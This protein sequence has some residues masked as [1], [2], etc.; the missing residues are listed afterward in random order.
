MGCPRSPMA[1]GNSARQPVNALLLWLQAFFS[2]TAKMCVRELRSTE[3]PNVIVFYLA[4]ISTLGALTG[5]VVQVRQ[6][7]MLDCRAQASPKALMHPQTPRQLCAC[8]HS[9]FAVLNDKVQ[10]CSSCDLE[11]AVWI[12]HWLKRAAA[13]ATDVCSCAGFVLPG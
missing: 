2:G 3:A 1:Y 11:K 12:G 7:L 10:I 13:H 4:F 9:T 8:F 6:Q 5:V